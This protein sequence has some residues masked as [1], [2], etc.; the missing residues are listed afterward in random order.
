MAR[1]SVLDALIAQPL[2][3]RIWQAPFADRKIRPIL[4]HNDL[5]RVRRVLDVA[6][7]PG[8]NTKHFQGV[9][10][11]GVDWNE[12]YIRHAIRHYGRRF[13][14]ADVTDPDFAVAG[15]FDFIL[16]NSVLHHLSDAEIEVLLAKLGPLLSPDGSIHLLELVLPSAPGVAGLLARLDRGRYARPLAEWYRL[17][18]RVFVP[19]L[20][21]PYVLRG[22]GVPLWHMVYF[23]GRL[24]R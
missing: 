12:D 18:T 24:A 19:E 23:K 20:F 8:T 7:G 6:C 1:I 21:E 2:T 11:L 3:Y 16:V 15:T 9:E 17:L 5:T 14:C 22:L 13:I 10:Y 4:T